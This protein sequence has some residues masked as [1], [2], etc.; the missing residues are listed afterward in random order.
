VGRGGLGPQTSPAELADHR[1]RAAYSKHV[2][3]SLLDMCMPLNG[4]V[5]EL[6]AGSGRFSAVLAEC[7]SDARLSLPLLLVE[8]GSMVSALSPTICQLATPHVAIQ[9]SA[10]QLPLASDSAALV[11]ASQAFHWFPEESYGE[12]HRVVSP[13]GKLGVYFNLRGTLSGEGTPVPSLVALEDLVSDA[14]PAD[15]P[16][17]QSMEWLRRL[18]DSRL[19][20]PVA[21][22]SF[23]SSWGGTLTDC[24]DGV[25]SVSG[26]AGRSKE[27]RLEIRREVRR[28]LIGAARELG[29]DPN[30]V[31]QLPCEEGVWVTE[32]RK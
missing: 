25:M 15:A 19:F 22:Q 16:R 24:V 18:E 10:E 26:I 9:A 2:V 4:P 27:D 12:I 11:V 1:G 8:P 3:R 13:G 32:P 23:A 30:G 31:L 5:V 7:L 6:G 21:H 20:G 17:A 29:Q 14:Y 28:L